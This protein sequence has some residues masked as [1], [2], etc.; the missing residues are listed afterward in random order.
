MQILALIAIQPVLILNSIISGAILYVQMASFHHHISVKL[1]IQV[2]R[3]ALQAQQ[4]VL[5]VTSQGHYRIY[6]ALNV[7]QG[8]IQAL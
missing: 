1:A 3:H 6:Q 2:V 8:V 5:R 4:I 7:W